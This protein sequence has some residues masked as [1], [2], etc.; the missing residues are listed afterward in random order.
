MSC[1]NAD[2]SKRPSWR[3]ILRLVTELEAAARKPTKPL[4]AASTSSTS[5]SSSTTT[6][7]PT[8]KN[9]SS[10]SSPSPPPLSIASP[11]PPPSLQSPPPPLL[12][13]TAAAATLPV[14]LVPPLNPMSIANPNAS[15]PFALSA[16]LEYPNR[17][18]SFDLA[19]KM[20]TGDSSNLFRSL[21]RKKFANDDLAPVDLSAA[22][23]QGKVWWKRGFADDFFF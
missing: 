19:A 15:Y 21:P 16:A 5:S 2:A 10:S 9:P 3:E 20:L 12:S 4:S 13:P 8:L 23:F 6:M 7:L 11:R 17:E 14:V 18:S 22:A 1:W